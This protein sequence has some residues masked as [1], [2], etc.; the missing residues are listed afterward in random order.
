[1]K[2]T[3]EMVRELVDREAIRDLPVRYCDCLWRKDV[4]GL[5]ELFTD[6]AT[7]VMKGIEIEAVSR[8][9]AQLKRMHEKALS[10][11]TPRL[12]VHNQIINLLGSD[13][14][15]GDPAWRCAM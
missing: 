4:D 6:D 8:G 9:R 3:D 7:F 5:L 11:T 2:T 15:T 1:M 10:E 14:A 12:F 13:R